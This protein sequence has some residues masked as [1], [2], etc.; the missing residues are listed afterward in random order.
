MR[1]S[2]ILILREENITHQVKYMLLTELNTM[3]QIKFT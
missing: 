3:G 1:F 2:T